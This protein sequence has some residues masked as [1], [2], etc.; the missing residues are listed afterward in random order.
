MSD[1][2]HML[3]MIP[4][5]L[6]VSSFMGYLKG[7]S[8]LMIFDRHANLKYKNVEI[9]IDLHPFSWIDIIKLLLGN[10]FGILPDSFLLI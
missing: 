9:D 6:S 10:E 2:V 1:H 7:K 4:P 8:V 5:K 3:V